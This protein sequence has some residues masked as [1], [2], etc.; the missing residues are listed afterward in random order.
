M[1]DDY[2]FSPFMLFS[3]LLLKCPLFGGPVDEFVNFPVWLYEC[4]GAFCW[5]LGYKFSFALCRMMR[6]LLELQ[7]LTRR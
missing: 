1:P 7:L 3:F 4:L 5:T 6:K 2:S